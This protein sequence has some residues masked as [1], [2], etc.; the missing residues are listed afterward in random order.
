[1]SK[2][3]LAALTDATE[4][5]FKLATKQGFVTQD[6]IL[7]AFGEPEEYVEQLDEFYDRLMQADVDIFESVSEGYL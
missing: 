6:D 1:M 2:K 3:S 7:E 5:L 4:Q